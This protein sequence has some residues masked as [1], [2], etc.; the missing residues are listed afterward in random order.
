MNMKD[1]KLWQCS[2][3]KNIGN[4]FKDIIACPCVRQL[5]D[6]DANKTISSLYVGDIA[7][8]RFQDLF[9]F[10]EIAFP[11]NRDETKNFAEYK[12]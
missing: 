10:G 4:Q 1:E 9:A 3:S 8:C 7:Q 6:A 2:I 5:P 11:I 12:N